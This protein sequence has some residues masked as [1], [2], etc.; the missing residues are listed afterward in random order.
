[1]TSIL[2]GLTLFCVAI[3]LVQLTFL[4]GLGWSETRRARR[5]PLSAD[6]PPWRPAAIF[7]LVPCLN[8]A[9]VIGATVGSLLDQ[10]PD[11]RV[12]V[13]DDASDDDTAR[14]AEQAGGDR[15]V[16]LRRTLPEARLGKGPALND[17]F[18]EIQRLV[19]DEGHDSSEVIVLV[20]DADGQLSPGAIGQVAP[21]FADERVGGA[22]LGVRI[23]NRRDNLLAAIQDC[24]FWGIAALGQMGRMRTRTVSLGGN[25]QFTRLAALESVGG[26]PWFRSLTEDLDLAVTLAV[27]GWHLTS[28]PDAWVSQ[29]GL[30]R[31]R[32]L[33]RQRT[34]W[35]QGHMTVATTRLGEVWRSPSL[36]N[37]AV[38]EM[39]SYLL[40]PFILVLP[41]SVLSQ[42]S[43]VSTLRDLSSFAPPVDTGLPGPRWLLPIAFWYVMSFA[44]TILCGYIYS[45]RE[46]DISAIRAVVFS[47]VLVLWNY[48]LFLACWRGVLR[49]VTG[50]TGWDKT[51]R[52]AEGA[53]RVPVSE[54]A[55]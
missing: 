32:P 7:A 48:V 52:V 14:I 5:A 34:R 1:V 12:V 23:R 18:A 22:Q 9:T 6:A 43:L 3:G 30:T 26:Q 36:P 54:P 25:G 37:L 4:L 40:I 31:V 47:H 17:A 39:T 55:A 21:L 33:L 8:E 35:F 16:V 53:A 20:M 24:E 11:L 10:H 44:P 49:M 2:G 28:T 51:A 15:V 45:R 13:I 38:L 41:W 46:K 19:A 29:Q 50:R 42:I 27:R